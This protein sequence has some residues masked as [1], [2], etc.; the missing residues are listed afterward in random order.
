MAPQAL[1]TSTHL[2][3]I[4]PAQWQ[5]AVYQGMRNRSLLMHTC[6]TVSLLA[7]HCLCGEQLWVL[8]PCVHPAEAHAAL[9]T[10]PRAALCRHRHLH[11]HLSPQLRQLRGSWVAQHQPEPQAAAQWPP[12]DIGAATGLLEGH[13]ARVLQLRE[14]AAASGKSQP[15]QNGELQQHAHPQ[16]NGQLHRQAQP[17]QDCR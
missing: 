2:A 9:L 10:S 16:Q 11:A 7:L 17:Q 1:V 6:F 12:A 8:S 15:Q 5:H 13:A 3:Y 14:L 4:P